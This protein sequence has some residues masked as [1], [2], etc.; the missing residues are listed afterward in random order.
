LSVH[1][2]LAELCDWHANDMVVAEDGR[3]YVGNF[4]FDLDGGEPAPTKLV[5]VDPHGSTHVAADGLLFPNGAVIDER[6]LIDGETF[7]R[8]CSAARRTTTPGGAAHRATRF[9]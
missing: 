2:D 8:R 3:A 1:A 5:R 6:T 7:G 9:C 4:G